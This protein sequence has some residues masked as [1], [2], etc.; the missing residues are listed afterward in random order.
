MID[1]DL[2]FI[3]EVAEPEVAYAINR[4]LNLA[5]DIVE[6]TGSNLF[7]T[8]RAGTGK[9]TF[10]HKLR[11]QSDKRLIVLAPTG[12]AAIN[13]NGNTIHSFFQLPFA[14]YI[15][16]KGFLTAEKRFLNI[17]KVKRN[18]MTSLSLL[19][20]DEVSMVRPDMLDA[21][22]N[23][24]RRVRDSSLPFGGVQLLLI[25]DLRQLPPVI[26]DKEWSLL[27]DTY[28]TPY[29]FDSVALKKAGFLTIELSTVY[30]QANR[31]FVHLL[32]DIRDG[33]ATRNTLDTLNRRYIPGFNP[34]DSE[35]YI[36]LTTHHYK[37]KNL[38]DSRLAALTSPEFKYEALIEGDFPE[39]SFPAEPS[40]I[41]K[42][43]AQV[44][45]IKN[46]TGPV[47]RYYNGLI[48]TVTHL[49]EEKVFVTPHGSDEAIEISPVEWTNTRYV[50]DE[51]TREITQEDVGVF[52]QY[53][54]QLAW[55]ITIHKSQG[56]TFD[57]AI[58]DVAN[59]FAPGQTYV[60]L[61]R[62]RT[63]EGLVLTSPV[64]PH[65]V[66]ADTTI[67]EFVE[68]HNSADIDA[69]EVLKKTY[70]S[71]LL[72]ELYDFQPLRRK[73]NDFTRYASEY[74]VPIHPEIENPLLSFKKEIEKDL[75]E[76]GQKFIGSYSV[77]QLA[78]ELPL[79]ASKVSERVKNGC[80]YF[81]EI[82]SRLDSFLK[83]LP[84]EKVENSEYIERLENSFTSLLEI[85][86][87]KVLLL[88][89]FSKEDF[90]IKGFQKCKALSTLEMEDAAEQR[91]P[92]N[93]KGKSRGKS[94]SEK[95]KKEKSPKKPKG[96]ST[97]ETFDIFAQGKTIEEIAL[98]RNLK[99]STIAGHIA[100]LINLKKIRVNEIF[101]PET[102]TRIRTMANAFPDA[103]SLELQQ[104]INAKYN[105]RKLPVYI[106]AIYKK[107]RKDDE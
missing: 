47:R 3:R 45:F 61:S 37:V 58:I 35:G 105:D 97:F 90:S 27:K 101:D 39:H 25:G 107:I 1:F 63:L 7:L 74:L 55:S 93:K 85:L 94:K 81:L 69:V 46:D 23:I 21:I 42:E 82:L 50:V 26:K 96:Y 89:N 88:Q 14:P 28:T 29:F 8:G 62:C 66:I 10:L 100:D 59:S 91:K 98:I 16:G 51:A 54:L 6:N 13:A 15:P 102:Y 92:S 34:P 71:T 78:S 84:T 103:T 83:S 77:D 86:T 18:I 56:L 19:V 22:D 95:A 75:C 12:V 32:N 36:R 33:N 48:G 53:P 64:P 11:E 72:S 52:T 40:L 41:L 44:M 9:T 67:N 24:L 73:Y 38:N 60:A 43:G 30:R 2:D 87:L 104:A 80:K 65:A 70:L 5:M 20:I 4:E 57:K 106:V 99:P 17:S 68:S 79:P 49:S 76:V 31:D